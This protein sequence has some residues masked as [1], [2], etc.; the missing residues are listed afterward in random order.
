MDGGAMTAGRLGVTVVVIAGLVVSGCGPGAV[1]TG[2]VR[3]ERA[4]A[5]FVERARAEV[6]VGAAAGEVRLVRRAAGVDGDAPD[7]VG[8]GSGAPRVDGVPAGY[9]RKNVWH[10]M[11]REALNL[12]QR[13][14]WDGFR[15]VYGDLENLL[16][17]TGTLGA[18]IAI[19]ATGVDDAI[20][21]RTDGSRQLGDFDEPIQLVGHPGMHFA[22]AGVLWLTS[23]VAKDLKTHEFARTL[24]QA[25]AVNGIST[26]AL[27]VSAN[28][29]A[30]NGD[31]M[32][33]P[34]GHTSSAFT[35]AA[36]VN[37][38]YG[39]LAGIPAFAVAGLVGYQRIDSRVHDFSD[40]VFGAM[41]GYV[42]GT[43]IARD[44]RLQFPELFGMEVV[45]YSDPVTGAS[46]LALVKRF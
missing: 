27:K 35:T 42:V 24:A 28:T 30:P 8:P 43:S 23:A 4:V 33:W 46:G 15:T 3:A 29:T 16:V 39:P 6:D 40:V 36:V 31:E 19:R 10:Q 44:K 32:A 34:S 25:L 2:G 5:A 12:G 1:G 9:W 20:R 17:L 45:P 11:G 21:R 41:L 37:E 18:S 13:E 14:L 22:A 26:M 7:M 38:Y